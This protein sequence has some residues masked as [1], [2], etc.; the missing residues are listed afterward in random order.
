MAIAMK[1]ASMPIRNVTRRL[2][3]AWVMVSVSAWLLPA[4]TTHGCAVCIPYPIK[5][6][7]DHL[8]QGS[9]VVLARENPDKPFSYLVS[10][11]LAGNVSDPAID[12]FLDSTTRRRL[13]LNPQRAAVLVRDAVGSRW[14]SLGYADEAYERVVRQIV[15]R[16]DEWQDHG[17]ATGARLA[18]FAPLLG[19]SNRRI[20]ELA[21]L[22]IGRAPYSRIK[23][24]SNAWPR[25]A[26][27]DLLRNPIYIEWYPLAILMLA[28]NA[29]PRDEEFIRS[30]FANAA[31][32]GGSL[33][34]GAWATAYIEIDG[35]EAVNAIENLY[36]RSA[37]R[38]ADELEAMMTA[39]SVHGTDGH[40]YLRDRLVR[41]YATLLDH[42]PQMVSFVA[43]DLTAWRRWDLVDRLREILEARGEDDP[44]SAFAIKMHLAQAGASRTP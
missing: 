3:L 35:E 36:F 37:R 28:H 9:A 12:L 29:E 17:A 44:L 10:E 15:Q 34:L 18:F 14:R 33:N 30:S 7:A 27:R 21:Y 41:S 31:R 24:F 5:T 13:S 43:K 1:E 6:V 39:L 2:V 26:I 32:F 8:V 40:T 42:Y 20:H 25:S 22:E 38:D 4:Q 11:T 19:N 16:A 23:E